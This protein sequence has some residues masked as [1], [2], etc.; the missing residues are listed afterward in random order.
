MADERNE[1]MANLCDRAVLSNQ[2]FLGGSSK[3]AARKGFT[4]VEL[5]VV[6][7]I[8]G[9]LVALLLP[10][11]QAARE[12]ARRTQC[13]NQVKQIMLSMHNHESALRGFPS[14]GSSTWPVLNYY[15][16]SPGGAPFGPD[17]QGLS[18]AFQILPYLEG[19]QVYRINDQ[20]QLQETP[21][22]MYNCPS[23][24]GPTRH[25]TA[26]SYL[27]DYAAA[28][29]GRTRS[30]MIPP[31][32]QDDPNP[33]VQISGFDYVGCDRSTLGHNE[34]WGAH[35][36]FGP[37]HAPD[38][39]IARTRATL[40]KLGKYYGF[41]GVI[42]RGDLVVKSNSP[43]DQII[44]GFYERIS[45]AQIP[46]GASNTM[47]L[48]EKLLQ[49]SEYDTGSIGGDD[50]GWSDG[51]DIDTLRSTKCMVKGDHEMSLAEQG[52][53][54]P[55]YRFGSAHPQTLNVGFADASVQTI[56][57][58]IDPELFNKLAHRADG[59]VADL[60]TL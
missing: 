38:F 53:G 44:T 41:W 51:W 11:V 9:V 55:D 50:R 22:P 46:D 21:V 20:V 32:D 28:V 56:R 1:A 33:H 12:A 31:L 37:I 36:P 5:L 7:A 25:V 58:D 29:P 48:G 35:L 26:E 42:V 54:H 24:R 34:Y 13:V 10:A 3:S 19:Q 23:R 8:I 27:M 43:G 4:L 60:G 18:W 16:V 40:E 57:F 6:I 39:S 14:G 15:L 59:E 47:V 30:E 52:T 2:A 45:F 49:P 17:K